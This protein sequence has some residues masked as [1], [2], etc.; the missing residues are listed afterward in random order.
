MWYPD[1]INY[2]G[3]ALA[4]ARDGNSWA[5]T[6]PSA[7]DKTANI[8]NYDVGGYGMGDGVSSVQPS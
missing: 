8:F 3:F 1:E 5:A 4:R 6:P 2:G 7:T